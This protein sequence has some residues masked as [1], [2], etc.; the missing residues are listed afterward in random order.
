MFVVP[1][2]TVFLTS[3]Y[4]LPELTACVALIPDVSAALVVPQ[5]R[6]AAER[7]PTPL[8]STE[9]SVVQLLVGVSL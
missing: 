1:L 4:H 9:F 3:K 8:T 2:A 5:L 6:L 7:F